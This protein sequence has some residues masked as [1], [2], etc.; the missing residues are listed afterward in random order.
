[1]S[2]AVRVVHQPYGH[3]G[4]TVGAPDTSR[5]L[6]VNGMDVTPEECRA[7]GSGLADLVN[8]RLERD[9]DLCPLNERGALVEAALAL[10]VY[11]EPT[12]RGAV[13]RHAFL[14]GPEAPAPTGENARVSPRRRR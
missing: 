13:A 4:R 12:V 9:P 10:G 2:D 11:D 8:Q 6:M 3:A 7:V 5:V 1:M 14:T